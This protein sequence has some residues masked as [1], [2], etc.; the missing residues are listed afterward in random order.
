MTKNMTVSVFMQYVHN[1]LNYLKEINELQMDIV[2]IYKIL[3]NLLK[4][5]EMF[6]RMLWSEK[7]MPFLS[8]LASRLHMEELEMKLRSRLNEKTFMIGTRNTPQRTFTRFR[9]L[10]QSSN[11]FQRTPSQAWTAIGESKEQHTTITYHWYGKVAN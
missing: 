9:N 11:N 10:N 1:L 8:N 4:K 3:K 2:I 6:V 7:V 5:Y